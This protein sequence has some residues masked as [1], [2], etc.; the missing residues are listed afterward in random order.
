MTELT[1]VGHSTQNKLLAQLGYISPYLLKKCVPYVL[2]PL[3]E[4][5]SV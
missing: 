4:L 3:L 2:Q 5:V 1:K